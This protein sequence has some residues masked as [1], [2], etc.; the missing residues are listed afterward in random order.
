MYTQSKA[1]P[2]SMAIMG[3]PGWAFLWRP[4]TSKLYQLALLIVAK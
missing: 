3:I 4:L 1:W 2:Q